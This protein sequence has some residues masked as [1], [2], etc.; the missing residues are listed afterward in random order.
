MKSGLTKLGKILNV[1]GVITF[2]I[3]KRIEFED[4]A[5]ITYNEGFN[6]KNPLTW[7]ILPVMYLIIIL[8]G[9]INDTK[10]MLKRETFT[11][12]IKK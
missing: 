7:L 2:R 3:E 8:N 1:L 4:E 6:L 12:T 5:K 10:G 11:K 9:G